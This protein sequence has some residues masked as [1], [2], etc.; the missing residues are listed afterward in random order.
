M[1]NDRWDFFKDGDTSFG[2]FYP[3]HYTLAGYETRDQA[4]RGA[5]ALRQAG[6]AADDVRVVDGRFLIDRLTSQDGAS[7]LDRV[8]ASVA[9]FIGT[10]T[11]FIDQDIALAGR[12]GAFVFVYTP[13]EEDGERV[14]AALSEPRPEHARRYLAMAI[15]RLVDPHDTRSPVPGKHGT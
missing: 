2:L 1:S 12:G 15:D 13:A 8:K 7:L 5:G 10:E 3:R 4:E 6:F 9:G 14:K 11:Y